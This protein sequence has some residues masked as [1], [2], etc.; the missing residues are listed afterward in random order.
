[1]PCNY[2]IQQLFLELISRKCKSALS[3][4]SVKV[5]LHFRSLVFFLFAVNPARLF[6]F[7]LAFSRSLFPFLS[8]SQPNDVGP[9]NVT[10]RSAHYCFCRPL[11]FPHEKDPLPLPVRGCTKHDRDSF[12]WTRFLLSRVP[13]Q[14]W[15]KRLSYCRRSNSVINMRAFS[16][17]RTKIILKVLDIIKLNL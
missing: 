14:W 3:Q 11:R 7:S 4:G 10:S 1:M 16:H 13:S 15:R 6:S 5:P 12:R 8:L 9:T 17:L 2:T